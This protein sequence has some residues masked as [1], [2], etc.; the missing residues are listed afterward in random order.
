MRKKILIVGMLNSIHFARWLDQFRNSDLEFHIWSS[1]PVRKP[2]PIILGLS[3]EAHQATYTVYS[4]IW[5]FSKII[6]LV[7]LL[8][9][10]LLRASALKREIQRIRPDIVHGV[11]F[12]HGC[13]LIVRSFDFLKV[14]A[15]YLIATNY[16]SDIYWFRKYPRH[17]KKIQKVLSVASAYSAECSRDVKLAKEMGFKGKILPVIPNSGGFSSEILL[18][19]K[20][21]ARDRSLLLVKGYQGW[22]GRARLA[23]QA[24]SLGARDYGE[25]EIVVFSCNRSTLREIS[26]I[27]K[28]D[29]LNIRG[30]KKGEL[31]HSQMLELFSKAKLYLGVSLSDGISTSMLEALASGCFPVQSSTSCANEWFEDGETGILLHDLSVQNIAAKVSLGLELANKS[32][33]T[34]SKDSE[35]FLKLNS[36]SVSQKSA[37]FYR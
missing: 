20:I 30:Y 18:A 6:W 29:N 34:I 31:S 9:G 27:R 32:T 22:V 2:H 33:P 26:R 21:P 4:N 23:L 7:D 11:E 19:P 24:I 12:Q 5:T 3:L 25:L 1:T 16:G 17:R 37:E 13:Y 8:L 36:E 28:K 10:N 15:P 14:P 35:L